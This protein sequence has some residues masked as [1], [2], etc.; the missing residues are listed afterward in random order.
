MPKP[1]TS[2]NHRRAPSAPTLHASANGAAPACEPN[3]A[4]GH[5]SPD[6]AGC[7]AAQAP[8]GAPAGLHGADAS[9]ASKRPGAQRQKESHEATSAPDAAQ[10]GRDCAEEIRRHAPAI[11]KAVI[12]A[13]EEQGSYLHAKFLFEFA[14]VTAPSTAPTASPDQALAAHLLRALGIR[15]GGTTDPL[16]PTSEEV[17]SPEHTL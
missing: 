13:A 6:L 4:N 9:D 11:T 3:R 2:R 17:R 10:T 5:C 15:A 1:K 8:S 7:L 14:G 12:A 16:T